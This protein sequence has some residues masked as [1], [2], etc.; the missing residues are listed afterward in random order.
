LFGFHLLLDLEHLQ[1]GFSLS[2]WE[3]MLSLQSGKISLRSCLLSRGSLS[4]LDSLSGE[5]FLFHFL[6]L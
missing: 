1:L 2:S 3:F 4:L 6:S 5:E